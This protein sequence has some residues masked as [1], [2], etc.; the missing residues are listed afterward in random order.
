MLDKAFGYIEQNQ[1]RFIQELQDF[2]KFPSVSTQPERTKDLRSCAQ[3]LVDHLQAI[4]LEARLIESK[5]HP[6]VWAKAAGQSSKRLIIYG[7]YDVQPEDPIDQWHTPPFEPT[8]R[9]GFIYARGAADDK[10]QLFAHVK[11]V[12][13]LIRTAGK[14]PCQV[15]FLFEGEEESGGVALKEY[16]SANKDDLAVDAIVVSDTGM[17][18]EKTPAITYGLRGI[19]AFEITLK[20]ADRDLHSGI[21]GGAVANPATALAHIISQCLAADGAIKI[22]GFHDNIKPLQDWEKKQIR[23]LTFDDDKLAKQIGAKRV[24]GEPGFSTLERIWARPTL[25]INGIASGYTGKGMKTIIPASATAKISIRLVPDQDPDRIFKVVTSH[26]KSLCPDYADIQIPLLSAGAPP[27]LFDVEHPVIRA[28]CR[29]LKLGFAAEPVFIRC[30][31]SI[32]VVNTFWQQLK[33]PVLLIGFCLDS[34]G[35]HSPNERFKIASFINAI[36]TSVALLAG[37]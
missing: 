30:G 10:G 35:A 9:D 1:H 24:F 28:G 8:I 5:G 16:I 29:A 12:E 4:G 15:L 11:G 26:L 17:Y 19:I 22:P 7:H 31:G 14:L 3:W 2:L 36:R 6:I 23:N 37:V 18:D 20:V 21:F 25:D 33:K 13:S 32:P 27:V 34:D